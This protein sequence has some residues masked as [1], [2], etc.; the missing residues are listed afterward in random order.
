MPTPTPNTVK[1]HPLSTQLQGSGD[2]RKTFGTA[3]YQNFTL[4]D[5]V[6]RKQANYFEQPYG[7]VYPWV[8]GGDNPFPTHKLA[9]QEEDADGEHVVRYYESD[10]ALTSQQ[11]S[12]AI[13]TFAG[14][15]KDHPIYT[16]FYVIPREIFSALTRLTPLSGLAYAKVSV[17]GSGYD[18][19]TIKATLSGGTGSGGLVQAF[20]NPQGQVIDVQILNAGS[21]TAAP[22]VT[23]SGGDGVGAVATVAI[24]PQ[25]AVLTKEDQVALSDPHVSALYI[26][27]RRIYET[28]PGPP[29][30]GQTYNRKLDITERFTKQITVKDAKLGD[31]RT[32]IEPISSAKDETTTWDDA[33]TLAE[34]DAYFKTTPARVRS[35]DL[36]EV[37]TSVAAYYNSNV[38][39][40]TSSTVPGGFAV[41]TS[42]SLSLSDHGH[43]QGSAAVSVSLAYGRKVWSNGNRPWGINC[44]FFVPDSSTKAEVIAILQSQ[45]G[46]LVASVVS[47][48]V[49]TSPSAN[50]EVGHKLYV[51]EIFQF[52]VL[53]AGHTGTIAINTPYVVKAVPTNNTFT[54]AAHIAD[55][56][57]TNSNA[58]SGTTIVPVNEMPLWYPQQH[59]FVCNGGQVSVSADANAQQTVV[60]NTSVTSNSWTVGKGTS[61][62]V[63]VTT[64]TD[65]TPPMIH[66]SLT[67]TDGNSNPGTLTPTATASA[68]VGSG[69]N[70]PGRGNS[71]TAP[72]ASV[73]ASVIA[74]PALGATTP[75]DWPSSGL[76]ITEWEP[77]FYELNRTQ[78]LVQLLDFATIYR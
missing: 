52:S 34:L 77:D 29:M 6:S 55:P 68:G 48:V 11:P 73:T 15:S 40:G 9:F 2:P 47:G 37:L 60:I 12:N 17:A 32:E 27:L 3:D 31:Q 76:Y 36:P 43:S 46:R 63:G 38:G 59:T 50:G 1:G 20:C 44:A 53:A 8:G 26:G 67:I 49:T 64:R 5:R 22:T 18:P 39:S 33:S 7:T 23:I 69:T 56:A 70:W 14:D 24:Q 75:S 61:E 72:T 62:E 65:Q 41:G 28:L 57:I 45:L 71:A 54:Y 51:G 4:I 74:N 42:A 66:G 16:R 78:M 30:A 13:I 19:R 58:A 35:L 10:W 21:Y 25:T